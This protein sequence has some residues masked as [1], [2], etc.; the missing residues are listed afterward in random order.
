MI[1]SKI[2]S[3]FLCNWRSNNEPSTL[4]YSSKRELIYIFA[5]SHVY[6]ATSVSQPCQNSFSRYMQV[7]SKSCKHRHFIHIIHVSQPL[8]IPQNTCTNSQA[9]KL[10]LGLEKNSI[11]FGLHTIS[12]FMFYI[13]SSRVLKMPQINLPAHVLANLA[14]YSRLLGY[15]IICMGSYTYKIFM[16]VYQK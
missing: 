15:H 14:M 5:S 11:G 10:W 13:R 8:V 9:I 6:H 16:H 2:L 3:I 12:N 1:N 4:L 7:S